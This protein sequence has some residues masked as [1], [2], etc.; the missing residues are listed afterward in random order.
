VLDVQPKLAAR[1]RLLLA[2][3]TGENDP[4]DARPVT[5]AG[6]MLSRRGRRA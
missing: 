6:G 5:P 3:N 2:G 1:A 4:D